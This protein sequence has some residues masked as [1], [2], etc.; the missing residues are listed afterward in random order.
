MLPPLRPIR[1]QPQ[2]SSVLVAAAGLALTVG[3]AGGERTAL[4]VADEPAVE[5]A[6]AAAP[7]PRLV[8]VTLQTGEIL[9]GPLA[10]APDADPL[11]IE[12]AVFGKM[13]LAR[14]MV[15]TI[16]GIE[17]AEVAAAAAEPPKAAEAA[18][19]EP[20]PP[21]P[22]PPPPAPPPP[23]P[24]PTPAAPAAPAPPAP[25]PAEFGIFDKWTGSVEA[26]FNTA[27][28]NSDRIGARFSL[29]LRREVPETVTT[30][31]STYNFG[32][33]NNG[34][35]EERARFDGRN[36]WVQQG[37]SS[38]RF[39]V[40]GSGEYD[41]F[42]RW[43]WRA[44]V[45]GGIGYDFI[46]EPDFTL[47]GRAGIGGSREYGD[48]SRGTRAELTPG[49]DLSWKI[50][51]R[52]RLTASFDYY[53]D[54]DEFSIYRFVARCAYDILLDPESKMTLRVGIED[55][56]DETTLAPRSKNDFELFTAIVFRF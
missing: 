7:S 47:I 26:G 32:R 31:N 24:A 49:L 36:D 53:R 10:S 8:T 22:P 5:T 33:N 52:S 34:I 40:A 54:L 41:R 39:F 23:P 6:A 12:H 51:D 11:V 15:K 1:A 20:A 42:Q 13:T 14:S 38:W 9:K 46:K 2:R 19:A 30:L 35:S 17:P 37:G 27:S 45:N 56:Y 3:V 21:A 16:E 48:L 25:P 28:G 44:S 43:D 55:R 50:D 4:G 18:P 29:G